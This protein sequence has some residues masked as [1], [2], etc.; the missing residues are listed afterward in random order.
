MTQMS[1]NRPRTPR[2]ASRRKS[3]LDSA[4]QPGLFKA[5]CDPTRASLLTCLAKCGRACSVSEVA[6]CCHVDLSVVSRHLAL[7]EAAGVIEGRKAGRVVSYRVRYAD[8]CR[9]LRALAD[10]METLCPHEGAC[11]CE[12]SNGCC[13]E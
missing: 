12:P 10:A 6:D 5:L 4:L 2:E 9:A 1:K 8:V 3:D 13:R 11:G 7:L